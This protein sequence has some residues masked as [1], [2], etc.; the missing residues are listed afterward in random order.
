MIA[1]C[2]R[3]SVRHAA[4]VC[5]NEL[6][7]VV[8]TTKPADNSLLHQPL[9]IRIVLYDGRSHVTRE[10]FTCRHNPIFTDI[11][12]RNHLI[13]CVMC[14]SDIENQEINMQKYEIKIAVGLW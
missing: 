9:A 13:V 2:I 12:P 4:A 11:A 1:S 14:N 6:N 3:Q 5:S 8:V 10:E 7:S